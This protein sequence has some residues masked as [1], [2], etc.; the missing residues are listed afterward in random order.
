MLCVRAMGAWGANRKVGIAGAVAAAGLLGASLASGCL[1]AVRESHPPEILPAGAELAVTVP[2]SAP[3]EVA[4]GGASVRIRPG[5]IQHTDA[6]VVS[7][8][9]WRKTLEGGWDLTGIVSPGQTIE[10]SLP[11]GVPFDLAFSAATPK[12]ELHRP[13]AGRS[14]DLRLQRV[15]PG[16]SPAGAEGGGRAS[17]TTTAADRPRRSGSGIPGMS[18]LT[19]TDGGSAPGPVLPST[20]PTLEVTG[21]GGGPYAG[22]SARYIFWSGRSP[23]DASVPAAIDFSDD[24]GRTWH[25]IAESTPNDGKAI[26]RLPSVTTEAGRL[27]VRVPSEVGLPS[28]GVSRRFSIDSLP[29]SARIE[30]VTAVESTVR[31]RPFARDAGSAGID[32]FRIWTTSGPGRP[33]EALPD[34]FPSAEPISFCLP[35]GTYGLWIAG[36]DRV[37]NRGEGPSPTDTPQKTVTIEGAAKSRSVCLRTF[38]GGGRHAGGTRRYVFW[39]CQDGDPI[40]TVAI[41]LSSDAGRTW[42]TVASDLEN[43]GRY[44]WTLP[45]ETGDHFRLRITRTLPGNATVSDAS[46]ADFRIDAESPR[47]FFEGPEISN[48]RRTA[49]NYRWFSDEPKGL[50][51]LYVRPLP[52]GRWR[53]AKEV[54]AGDPIS[55]ELG[56]GLYGIV[57]TAEDE[58][59]NSEPA[60]SDADPVTDRILVDTVAPKV[61]VRIEPESEP[62]RAGEIVTFHPRI[63]DENVPPFAFRIEQSIDGGLTWTELRPFHA[64]GHPFRLI[65]PDHMGLVLVRFTG[66]D[67]AGNSAT[68]IVP[69]NVILP[70]PEATFEPI[71]EL[72]EGYP[73]RA[74]A[75]VNVRWR[76]RGIGSARTTWRLDLST[77][78]GTTW[79]AQA[80]GEGPGG[81]HA[82]TVPGGLDSS[83]CILRLQVTR[84]DGAVAVT[85]L[86]PFSVASRAP[87]V[88]L[89]GSVEPAPPRAAGEESPGATSGG[90]MD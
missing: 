16:E 40:G 50:V 88:I 3:R 66:E 5:L 89:T 17:P 26:V 67:L 13:G 80:S 11:S 82:W 31:V 8:R 1:P 57:L 6:D 42:R 24:D 75:I 29:P 85:A 87:R 68:E 79:T 83:R 74:G 18:L 7:Y 44:L 2:S 54:K 30:D 36:E 61:A 72:R 48:G 46:R 32:R 60:P 47:V 20:G 86:D 56:D 19:S 37:G 45:H 62:H 58:A 53:L 77:D 55:L 49:V 64:P 41:E 14:P 43:C 63:E 69:I 81:V 76:T 70:D 84:D 25:P 21:I 90:A 51:R 65:L 34:A 15:P 10:L 28:I 9:V 27:R 38:T 35:P 33:W 78:G 71:A 22:E 73:L 39:E 12:G 59:G 4:V 52:D 23:L